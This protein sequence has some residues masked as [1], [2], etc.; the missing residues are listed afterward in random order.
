VI[1]EQLQKDLDRL[2]EANIPVDIIFD[3]GVEVLGL[4]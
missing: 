3:Q 2:T 1:R 4:D